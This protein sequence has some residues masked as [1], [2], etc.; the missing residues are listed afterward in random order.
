V[1]VKRRKCK[2]CSLYT[3]SFLKLPAGVFCNID[4]AWAFA[5]EK[6]LRDNDRAR[7]KA[8]KA[9]KVKHAKQKREYYDNDRST[10]T[11][12]AQPIWS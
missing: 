12:F 7:K 9:K 11:K 2:Q 8:E 3:E 1:S 10:R 4:H 6:R 5:N